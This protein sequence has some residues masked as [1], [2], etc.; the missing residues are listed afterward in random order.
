MSKVAESDL[1]NLAVTSLVPIPPS[2]VAGQQ[3]I[4]QARVANFSAEPRRISLTLDAGGSRQSQSLDLPALAS[5]S[6]PGND[7]NGKSQ[8]NCL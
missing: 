8:F 4:V 7:P 6:E 2:P 3:I 1:A 5:S